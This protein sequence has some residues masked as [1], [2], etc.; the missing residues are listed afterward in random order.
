MDKLYKKLRLINLHKVLICNAPQTYLDMIASDDF[1]I[2]TKPNGTYDF[3]Q[4]FYTQLET[5]QAETKKVISWLNDSAVFWVGYPKGTSKTYSS[6]IN[7]TT[8]WD[9]YA[10]FEFEPVSQVAIDDDWSAVRYKHVDSIKK[11]TRKNAATQ[12]GKARVNNS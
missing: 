5:A 8:L 11:L 2:D 9:L 7:R 10:D 6:D 1:S 3:V 12:K 4:V